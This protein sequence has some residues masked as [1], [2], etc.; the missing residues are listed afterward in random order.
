[1]GVMSHVDDLVVEA[2]KKRD[3]ARQNWALD[4]YLLKIP[5]IEL[6]RCA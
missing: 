3:R 6:L 2:I 4:Q 1:M 5:A